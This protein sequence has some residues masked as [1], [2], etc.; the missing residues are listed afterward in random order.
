MDPIDREFA[1][2]P[3]DKATSWNE[4]VLFWA[5]FMA[6]VATAFGF[7]VRTQIIEDWGRQFSLS[8]TQQGEIFGVGNDGGDCVFMAHHL[9]DER[10]HQRQGHHRADAAQHR[11]AGK[12]SGLVHAGVFRE[13]ELARR[14]SS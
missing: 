14:A 11:A 5:S 10:F 9:V 2:P 7:V 8:K 13:R 6:I 4:T 1:G 3:P 12:T